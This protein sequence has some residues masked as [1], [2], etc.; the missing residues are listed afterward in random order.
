MSFC[1]DIAVRLVVA[2]GILQ[3]KPSWEGREGDV[4]QK[5]VNR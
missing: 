2:L 5:H 4:A 3:I 1:P